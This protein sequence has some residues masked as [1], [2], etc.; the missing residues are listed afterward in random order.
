[1]PRW[2]HSSTS[3]FGSSSSYWTKSS[4][5]RSAKS[6]IGNTDLNTSCRPR[7]TRS[8]GRTFICRKFSYEVRCTSIR[9]GI[10]VTSGMCPKLLRIR[11]RPVK[12]YVIAIPGLFLVRC[13][14]GG[15]ADDARADIAHRS[16]GL[17]RP[18]ARAGRRRFQAA[19]QPAPADRQRRRPVLALRSTGAGRSGL[20]D[21]HG[22]PG[23]FELLLEFAGLLLGH[24]LLD[25]L[26]SPS[27]RSFASLRP[28]P[29]IARTSLMTLIFLSPTAARITSNSVF[30]SASSSGAAAAPPTAAIATG[31]AAET[32]H[33]SSSIFDSSAASITLSAERSSTICCRLAIVPFSSTRNPIQ[34]PRAGTV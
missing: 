31:A 15:T 16:A 19:R 30:S 18:R 23:A 1:M 28:R 11:F 32:P 14:N 25:R 2:W 4:A 33:F 22:R 27:T 20:F 21:L 26:G 13:R 7:R 24:P 5:A 8:C 29:V 6:R 9:L 3:Y 10:T 17:R 34:A 12:E